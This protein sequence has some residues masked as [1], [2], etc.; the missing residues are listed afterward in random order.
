MTSSDEPVYLN[1]DGTVWVPAFAGQRPPF[2]PGNEMA[3][4]PGNLMALKHGANTPSIVDP[5][6]ARIIEVTTQDAD[7]GYLKQPMFAYS[8]QRFAEAEARRQLLAKW[9][10]SMSLEDAA[11]SDRGQTSPLE[12]LRKWSVT[13]ENSASKLGL[14]PVSAAKLQSYITATFRNKADLA[15]LLS[16]ID[17]DH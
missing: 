6:A 10:D 8:L 7:M 11:K 5:L 12:L 15:R 9:V 13:A 3:V 1:P 2:Q 17:D 16:G 14:D 4:K